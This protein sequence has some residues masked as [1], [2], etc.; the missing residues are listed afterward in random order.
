MMM[1]NRKL[2]LRLLVLITLLSGQVYGQSSAF[3]EDFNGVST[4]ALPEGWS[5]I[6]ETTSTGFVQTSTLYSP[7]SP[8]NQVRFYNFLDA[9]ATL[10]LVSPLATNFGSNWLTFYTKMSSST[11][12]A[13]LILGVL[14]D[15]ADYDTFVPLDTILVSGAENQRITYFF[16]D[17]YTD[18]DEYHIGFSFKAPASLRNLVVDYVT[19]EEAPTGPTFSFVPEDGDLGWADVNGIISGAYSITNTGIGV[20]EIN[21]TDVTFAGTDA[22]YFSMDA[23]FPLSLGAGENA[24]VTI[25]FEPLT[26]GEKTAELSIEHNAPNSP[27]TLEVSGLAL[28]AVSEYLEGFDASLSFPQGW[29]KNETPGLSNAG[30]DISTAVPAVSGNNQVRFRNQSFSNPLLMLVGPLVNSF[31]DNWVSFWARQNAA[32]HED[33]VVVGVL[34]DR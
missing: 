10:V 19:W 1:R 22:A 28:G 27:F 12:I 18:T 5:A 9:N 13:D 24:S 8:P 26:P 17:T 2:L 3:F 11:H 31:E 20:L 34:T 4:P 21:E 15:P 6:E 29:S 25:M 7:F 33:N 30:V 32:A 16:P 23:E 14:T